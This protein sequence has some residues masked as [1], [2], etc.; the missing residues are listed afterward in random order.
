MAKAAPILALIAGTGALLGVLGVQLRILS[1]MTGFTIFVA[2]ALLGGLI[3]V[4]VSAIATFLARGGRN[5]DGMRLG[6]AGLTV[7]IGL[8][9]VVFVA[10]SPGRDLPPINDIST[11]LEN[12]PSF[13]PATVVPDYVG[14]NMDY[15]EE[16]VP[17]VRE[18]YP[19]LQPI[20]LPSSP[21]VAYEKALATAVSLGWE[22]VAESP[23]RLVFDAQDETELFRFVD[24]ITVRVS[25]DGAGS[26]VDVRS[27]SRDGQ[28]DLGAN[29]AR[30]RR[31]AEALQR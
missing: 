28:G 15:P 30:I 20:R 24:D 17:Q 3:T 2:S 26:K 22:I 18:A 19:D 16:F 10:A 13:A 5:P 4:V 6:L 25:A 1:P 31:F 9:L 27:K 7:G 8:L 12:P 14:R 21:R 11:D 23:E 29:A